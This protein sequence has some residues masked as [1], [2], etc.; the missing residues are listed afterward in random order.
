MPMP[1]ACDGLWNHGE[2]T[3]VLCSWDRVLKG[4]SCGTARIRGVYSQCSNSGGGLRPT[5]ATRHLSVS[6]PGGNVASVSRLACV[7]GI[8]QW[9]TLVRRRSNR[10][11]TFWLTSHP[12]SAM[13]AHRSRNSGFCRS[14]FT[15][16]SCRGSV[17]REAFYLD[18]LLPNRLPAAA[19]HDF[20][21]SLQMLEHQ[22][23]REPRTHHRVNPTLPAPGGKFR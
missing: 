19:S 17:I 8:A 2:C 14:L 22:S 5:L 9:R 20:P 18:T 12:G 15:L 3:N 23:A 10:L 21:E 13:C 4:G 11:K 1:V 16:S 6:H 7:I